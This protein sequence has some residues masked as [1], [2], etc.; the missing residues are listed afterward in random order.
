MKFILFVTFLA[1]G[2][3][4]IS[5]QTWGDAS[6]RPVLVRPVAARPVPDQVQTRWVFYSGVFILITEKIHLT[7]RRS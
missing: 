6:G 5:A 7:L 4:C 1:V 2:I 3:A